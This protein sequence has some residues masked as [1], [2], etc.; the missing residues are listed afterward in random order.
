MLA[1]IKTITVISLLCSCSLPVLAKEDPKGLK[2]NASYSIGVNLGRQLGKSKDDINLDKFI[3]GLQD[4]FSGKKTK[5]SDEEMKKAL[6]A[7]R[8]VQQKRQ[9]EKQQMLS[10]KNAEEGAAYLAKNKKK[11]G[12]TTLP[13]GLQYEVIKAGKGPSPKASDTVVTHYHGTLVD[14]TVFDSSVDRGQ[15]ATFPVSGVIKGWTEALQKMKVGSK[16]KLAVPAALA[17][18]DRSAGGKIGPGSVLVF[19]VELLEIKD[20]SQHKH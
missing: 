2:D 1:K 19:D 3:E 15:P 4:S 5:L 14:G 13:S 17:Y 8:E 18:G 16:W 12:V 9:Q 11:K 20:P 7:F 10:K 6:L